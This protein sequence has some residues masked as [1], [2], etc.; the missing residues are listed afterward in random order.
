MT[1]PIYDNI[2]LSSYHALH[3]FLQQKVYATE[4]VDKLE[5]PFYYF[6]LPYDRTNDKM[7]ELM[8]LFME[9]TNIL[10]MFNIKNTRFALFD[11]LYNNI[12]PCLYSFTA[13]LDS[14]R[15]FVISPP[16]T[17]EATTTTTTTTTTTAAAKPATA[18]AAKGKAAT[19][20]AKKPAATKAAVA[21]KFTLPL[22]DITSL[23]PTPPNVTTT[24]TTQKNKI[25]AIDLIFDK[26]IDKEMIELANQ[27]EQETPP[28][29]ILEFLK[30]MTKVQNF[31][32]SQPQY[33]PFKQVPIFARVR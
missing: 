27:T 11:V 6:V 23:I 28:P 2:D 25:V 12:N 14:I 13:F 32:T 1:H 21:K 33:S 22:I 26:M 8:G 24:T 9:L 17:N 18:P 31:L 4:G 3:A 10:K 15:L 7:Q 20:A 29:T 30:Y 19:T 5:E 16:V